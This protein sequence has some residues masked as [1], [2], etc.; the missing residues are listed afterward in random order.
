MCVDFM[1]W[2]SEATSVASLSG[3]DIVT[4]THGMIV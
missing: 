1:P 2:S 3:L 4:E